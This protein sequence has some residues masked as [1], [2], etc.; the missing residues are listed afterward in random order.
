MAMWSGQ[1]STV[2]PTWAKIHRKPSESTPKSSINGSLRYSDKSTE[3]GQDHG[4]MNHDAEGFSCPVAT[5][6]DMRGSDIEAAHRL[7]CPM[8]AQRITP[9]LHIRCY[10]IND[11]LQPS[12]PTS[13]HTTATTQ[14]PTLS[15][16]IQTALSQRDDDHDVDSDNN[17]GH[18]SS[19]LTPPRTTNAPDEEGSLLSP[20]RANSPCSSVATGARTVRRQHSGSIAGHNSG[21]QAGLSPNVNQKVAPSSSGISS[22]T[23]TSNPSPA[24]TTFWYEQADQILLYLL[25]HN[26]KVHE[27]SIFL[28]CMIYVVYALTLFGL[29]YASFFTLYMHSFWPCLGPKMSLI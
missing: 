12:Q 23:T 16:E 24:L 9:Q 18:L 1:E 4:A 17:D 15:S 29:V 6:S 2:S 26:V 13:H 20:D 8:C 11:T 14:E 3:E 5:V 7:T 25:L 28:I 27:T 22:G 10:E 21:S 19:R